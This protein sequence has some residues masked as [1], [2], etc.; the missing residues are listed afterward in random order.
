VP[1]TLP[2]GLFITSLAPQGQRL[3]PIFEP[4]IDR[5]PTGILHFFGSVDV[6]DTVLRV[7]I[8]AASVQAA[9]PPVT[10]AASISVS[11][12]DC[13]STRVGSSRDDRL[14]RRQRL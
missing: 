4:Q 1:V 2:D 8:V 5:Q 3:P 9:L 13:A 12:T 10:P 11:E 6:A 14:H 7:A